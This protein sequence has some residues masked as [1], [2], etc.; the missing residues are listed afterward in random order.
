MQVDCFIVH[1]NL[2][3]VSKKHVEK[4]KT[5]S[6][7]DMVPRDPYLVY[8]YIYRKCSNRKVMRDK[9]HEPSVRCR[10][11]SSIFSVKNIGC[12]LKVILNMEQRYLENDQRCE[13]KWQSLV[14]EKQ[15]PYPKS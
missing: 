15:P 10:L 4:G 11:M 1:S 12:L 5:Q 6:E 2:V 9:D 8:H 3:Y 14:V 13:Y 7:Q